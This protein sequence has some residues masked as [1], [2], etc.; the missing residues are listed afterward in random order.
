MR[1][2]GQGGWLQA[3]PHYCKIRTERKSPHLATYVNM[4]VRGDVQEAVLPQH[5][6]HSLQLALSDSELAALPG[7]SAP[8]AGHFTRATNA[9][10]SIY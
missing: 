7:R 9:S 2:W 4:H 10:T 1:H 8:P 6:Q 5:V 3:P